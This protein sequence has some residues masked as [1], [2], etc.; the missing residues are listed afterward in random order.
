MESNME[1]NIKYWAMLIKESSMDNYETNEIVDLIKEI[2]YDCSELDED[3]IEVNI[4]PILD[5]DIEDAIHELGKDIDEIC[6]KLN[7]KYDLIIDDSEI[8][9]HHEYISGDE[10]NPRSFPGVYIKIPIEIKKL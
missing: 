1:N 5:K 3:L 2:G 10:D 7:S 9:Y 4:G 8:T 6:N